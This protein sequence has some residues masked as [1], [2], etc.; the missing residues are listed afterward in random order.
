MKKIS[1][2][3]VLFLI[4]GISSGIYAQ[5][6]DVTRTLSLDKGGLLKVEVNP[7]D[8]YIRTWNKNEV[9]VKIA[10]IDEDEMDELEMKSSGDVVT[11]KYIGKWGWGNSANYSITVPEIVDLD[12]Y[13]TG[14][15]IEI[16]NNINGDVKVNTMGGDIVTQNIS[17]DGKLETMGGN[18]EFK[19]ISGRA[20]ITSQGGDLEG[21]DINGS[22]REVKTMG[23]DIQLGK[24]NNVN[25]VTTFGGDIE[26]SE[27]IGNIELTTFGGNIELLKA[28][29]SV[30]AKSYGGNISIGHANGLVDVNTAAGNIE[31]KQI[32]GFVNARTSAGNVYVDL[33]PTGN[34]ESEI[35]TDA[36]EII[37]ILPGNAKASIEAKS[38]A[39]SW[40]RDNGKAIRSDF[41]GN[42][43]ER[44]GDV[45]GDFII[46]GGGNKIYLKT[47]SGSI[48]I[49]KKN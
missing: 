12:L 11:I 1:L 39:S 15:D 47:T 16:F 46:N 22:A 33:S 18:I 25:K 13:S 36:G 6:E 8:I 43:R 24:I 31:L 14:G 45:L 23:G 3:F 26:I 10:G 7:G 34:H 28:Q 4:T 44:R 20:S 42:I 9:L 17:G 30:T 38:I 40:G 41:E 2:L 29:N 48:Q 32:T 37:L 5:H 21:G 49:R 35:R 19:N 27:S